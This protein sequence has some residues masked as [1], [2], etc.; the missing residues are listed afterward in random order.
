MQTH[1][2]KEWMQ[3]YKRPSNATIHKRTNMRSNTQKLFKCDYNKQSLTLSSP[4]PAANKSV[5][6][7]T[8]QCAA[9]GRAIVAYSDF[10]VNLHN[11]F[12][13]K[14]ALFLT[15]LSLIT[16]LLTELV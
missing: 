5:A 10:T 15:K 4:S 8:K 9:E 13:S 6:G 2:N 14:A 11:Y 1:F 7:P 3:T 16:N 12:L